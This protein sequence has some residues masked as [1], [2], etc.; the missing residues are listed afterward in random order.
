MGSSF[1]RRG[2]CVSGKWETGSPLIE[3]G[4][5]RRML[6]CSGGKKNAPEGAFMGQVRP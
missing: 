5:E 6:V 3:G 4:S 2:E 1:E